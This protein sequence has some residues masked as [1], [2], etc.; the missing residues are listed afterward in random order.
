MARRIE[1][2]ILH[3][4]AGEKSEKGSAIKMRDG[5]FYCWH[6]KNKP[7]AV[8]ADYGVDD[9]EI[10]QFTPDPEIYAALSVKG[11]RKGISIEMCSIYD[12]SIGGAVYNNK[13]NQP[14]QPQW[15]F[16]QEVL[17]NTKKLIIELFKKFGPLNITTHYRLNK[18]ACPGVRGWNKGALYDKNRIIETGKSDESVLEQYVEEI[19]AEWERVA[20]ASG[21]EVGNKISLV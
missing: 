9:E 18:K 3:Y 6:N 8:S 19:W 12:N 14:N 17:T 21:R 11:N 1:Y 10:V 5:W 7:I 16:S 4:T 13:L 20:T 2:I 15:K